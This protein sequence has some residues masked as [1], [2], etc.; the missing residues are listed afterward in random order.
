MKKMILLV[1]V[2][3]FVLLLNGVYVSAQEE[4][5]WWYGA[6]TPEQ[7]KALTNDFIERFHS[8]HE[9]F[10]LKMRFDHN[11]DQN[12][13]SAMLAGAGPD[14]VTTAG[15]GYVQE[16]M[17]ED[18]LMPLDEYAKKYN[19]YKR[20]L[21]IVI[22][23]GTFDGHLYA[24]PTTYESMVLFYN[25][26]LFEENGWKVPTD[27]NELE[28]LVNEMEDKGIIPFAQGNANWRGNNE[29]YVGVFLN[30]FAGPENIYKALTG[31]L[32]WNAPVFVDAIKLLDKYFNNHFS[33]NYYSLTSEDFVTQLA[34]G[35]AGMSIIGTWGFQ[36][37]ND[38][39]GQT[40]QEWDWAPFPALNE[41]VP[42]PL[43]DLGIGATLS[44]NKKSNNA[45]GAALAIDQLTGDKEVITDINKDWPGEWNMPIT[46]LNA[47]DFKGKVDPRYARHIEEVAD[48]VKKGGYGYTLWTFWP[49]RTEQYMLRGIEQVWSGEVTPE[50]YLNKVNEIFKEELEE[51]SVPPIP[52]RN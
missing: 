28:Q 37:M 34:M 21:P 49:Q 51:G 31:K 30:H 44:I 50:E 8:L 15:V 10:I 7:E 5:S 12:L 3:A 36:W 17:Q 42:Y 22:D 29:H 46:I 43:Y 45:D 39:F 1:L 38:Y 33:K 9:D 4:V 14:I 26:T 35:R 18:Y 47:E 24:L 23:L 2:L 6:A 16:Y 25:K 27:I 48:S 52:E 13:R 19:W 32:P 11:L 41:N 40:E 20:F